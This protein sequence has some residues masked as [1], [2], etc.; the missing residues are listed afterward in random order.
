M[1]SEK[2]KYGSCFLD[3]LVFIDQMLANQ[4]FG[5]CIGSL[6]MNFTDN[7]VIR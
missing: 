1:F 2:C 3:D 7:L 6:G 5:S 4:S